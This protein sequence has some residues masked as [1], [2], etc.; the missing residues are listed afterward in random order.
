MTIYDSTKEYDDY[1]EEETF[2]L[3]ANKSIAEIQQM[4]DN[5][6]DEEIIR[7]TIRYYFSALL[8]NYDED[9]PLEEDYNGKPLWVLAETDEDCGLSDL[10]KMHIIKFSQTPCEGYI[11][12]WVEGE[13][14]WS[15][16]D[17]FNI[18]EQF[19][20]LKELDTFI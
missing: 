3:C 2:D 18:K 14:D 7:Q 4:F 6:W 15:D 10:E 5:D 13:D 17:R 8:M 1:N 11:N 19:A 16:I 20:I 9:E 12:F